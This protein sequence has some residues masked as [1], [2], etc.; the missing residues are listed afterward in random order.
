[1]RLPVLIALV[2]LPVS[3]WAA[4]PPAENLLPLAP[5]NTW[6][7][8]VFGQEDK[9]V[10]KVVRR[11]MVGEHTAFVM[12]AKLRDRV[13]ATEH[14]ALTKDG[15]CRVRAEKEDINP[16][17]YFLKLPVPDRGT[18]WEQAYK[19]NGRDAQARFSVDTAET[20]VPFGKFKTVVVRGEIGTEGRWRQIT[21]VWYA[22]DVG[23]VKQTIS[24]GKGPGPNPGLTLEL[25][26]FDKGEK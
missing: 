18:R 26:K 2:A 1:M 10:V 15:F 9:F 13:V 22:P 14:V 23:I 4:D 5:G 3:A 21:T 11:E 20:T 24:E 16:P 7:Y 19:L 12:E 8:R 17:V 6:T 25:E